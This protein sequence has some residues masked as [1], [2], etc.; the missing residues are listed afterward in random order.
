MFIVFAISFSLVKID[1]FPDK[2]ILSEADPFS[3]KYGFMVRQ[4]VLLSVMSF[5][6]KFLKY[7]CF[8]FRKRLNTVILLGFIIAPVFISA[9]FVETIFKFRSVHDYFS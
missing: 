7:Y 9:A 5:K 8:A 6:F 3:L 2:A 1:S 4:K